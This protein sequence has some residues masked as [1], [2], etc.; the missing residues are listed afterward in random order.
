MIN[1]NLK[2]KLNHKIT[3][4]ETGMIARAKTE[5]AIMKIKIAKKLTQIKTIEKGLGTI[6]IPMVVAKSATIKTKI[7]N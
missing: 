5:T 1:R 4:K 7:R 2:R 6:Q 3:R